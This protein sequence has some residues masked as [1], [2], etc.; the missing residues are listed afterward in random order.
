MEFGR[1]KGVFRTEQAKNKEKMQ[2][3]YIL[4]DLFWVFLGVLVGKWEDFWE[5]LNSVIS[6]RKLD[7]VILRKNIV[8]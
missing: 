1:K 2:I 8:C 6:V 5:R 4:T 3:P 7:F